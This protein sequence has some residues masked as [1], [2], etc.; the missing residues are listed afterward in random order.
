MFGGNFCQEL[1]ETID[2]DIMNQSHYLSPKNTE[3]QD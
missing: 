3:D 1:I 2:G